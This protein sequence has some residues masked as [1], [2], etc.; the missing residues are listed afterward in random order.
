MSGQLGPNELGLGLFLLEL[1]E[2]LLG[3]DVAAA[4]AEA[5]AEAEADDDEEEGD[6]SDDDDEGGGE[7]EDADREERRRQARRRRKLAARQDR[8]LASLY[9][10]Q[11]EFAEELVR[12]D[13]PWQE[14]EGEAAGRRGTD[15]PSGTAAEGRAESLTAE[16]V[17]ATPAPGEKA[18]APAAAPD[19]S[20]CS[21]M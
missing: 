19:G 8:A 9:L 4:E 16:A 11:Q 10:A 14:L 15:W 3:V 6:D 1:L 17:A 2:L 21:V 13:A 12:R 18:A 7:G 20:Y 5:E